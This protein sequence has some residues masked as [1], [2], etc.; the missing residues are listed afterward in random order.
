M[1]TVWISVNADFRAIGKRK[2]LTAWEKEIQEDASFCR[3]EVYMRRYYQAIRHLTSRPTN[4]RLGNLGN[5]ILSTI[6]LKKEAEHV[7]SSID[8]IQQPI[9]F[10]YQ[11]PCLILWRQVT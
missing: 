8:N 11:L 10:F 7:L 6:F 3:H 5:Q 2:Q 4:M 9:F 1:I